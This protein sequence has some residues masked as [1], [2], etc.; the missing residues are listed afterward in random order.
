MTAVRTRRGGLRTSWSS[1]VPE[2]GGS[3]FS[4]SRGKVCVVAVVVL[5]TVP[6]LAHGQG[7][8]PSTA[9]FTASDSATAS[10]DTYRWYVTGTTQ[11]DVSIVAGGTV[12]FSNPATAARPHNVDFT[13]P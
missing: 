13:D 10:R 8:P 2:R 6:A 11:T 5:V 9:S 1:R 7:S 12:S 3:M 4:S